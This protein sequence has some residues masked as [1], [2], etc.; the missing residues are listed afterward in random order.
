M[1][2][3]G[4]SHIMAQSTDKLYLTHWP[5]P[6]FILTSCLDTRIYS[7]VASYC[8]SKRKTMATL[9]SYLITTICPLP[10]VPPPC[11]FFFHKKLKRV[12]YRTPSVPSFPLQSFFPV[13][14]RVASIAHLPHL[15]LGPQG[16]VSEVTIS[17]VDLEIVPFQ[18]EIIHTT[19]IRRSSL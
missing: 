11:S 10:G 9:P 18:L 3:P 19:Y 4:S 15:S 1:P 14:E 13:S 2:Q 8:R 6:S 7:C 17:L 5:V 16:F 12:R